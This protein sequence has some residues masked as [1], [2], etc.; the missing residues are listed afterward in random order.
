MEG[1]G[2]SPAW[3]GWEQVQRGGAGSK[4]SVEGLGASPAWRGWEQVQHG[5]AESKSSV[6]GLG[7]SPA[8]RGWEQIQR[9]GAGSKSSVEGL[10]DFIVSCREKDESLQKSVLR[11][12]AV[13]EERHVFEQDLL[14]KFKTIISKLSNTHTHTYTCS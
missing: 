8:W 11:I 9:G 3:R 10:F 14:T 2:A 6:E 4:S 7:A 5:W 1:L 13:W 12:L